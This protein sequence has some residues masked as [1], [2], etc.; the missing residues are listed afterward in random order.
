MGNKLK[1]KKLIHKLAWYTL[2]R[3]DIKEDLEKY[4]LQF[5]IEFEKELQ[6]LQDKKNKEEAIEGLVEEQEPK[7]KDRRITEEMKELHKLF[8]SIAKKT[9]PDLYGDEFVE[10]FKSANEAFDNK[11]W[12]DLITIAAELNIELPEFSDSSIKLIDESIKDI[13]DSLHNWTNSICWLW[14]SKKEELELNTSDSKLS[15]IQAVKAQRKK[16]ERNDELKENVR[17]LLNIDEKEFK[18]FISQLQ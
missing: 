3:E 10:I 16:V 12:I 13:E 14:A 11:Q 1:N 18:E 4:D 5:Q 7:E 17:K 2:E 8:R 15:P 6:F 9:H